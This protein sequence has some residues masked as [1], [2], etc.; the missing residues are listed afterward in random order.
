MPAP[1]SLAA[2]SV[3]VYAPLYKAELTAREAEVL[4]LI[5]RGSTNSGIA[6]SRSLSMR[7]VERHIV[8][9]YTKIGAHNRAGAI[10]FALSLLSDLLP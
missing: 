9:V 6:A 3:P 7:T 1:L 10:T 2:P 8:N 4:V 5:A